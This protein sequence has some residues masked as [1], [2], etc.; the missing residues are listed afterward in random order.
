[1]RGYLARI[2]LFR[3]LPVAVLQQV[4]EVSEVRRFRKGEMLFEENRPARTVWL[5]QRGWVHVVKRT[6]QGTLATL[7]TVTPEEVL[8]G[9]SAVVGCAAYYASAI[10]ATETAAVS[11]PQETFARLIK[12]Q[13]GFAEDFL[14]L[15]HTRMQHL[16]QTVSLAQAPVEQRL[17]HILLRLRAAFGRTLPVTHHE[18]SRMAG[19]RWETSI[20]T[21]SSMKQRGWI[22]SS[23]GQ[24]TILVPQ[25]L[26]MLLSNGRASE[27][28]PPGKCHEHDAHHS[29]TK[30]VSARVSLTGR[31]RR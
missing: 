8:C 4:G 25:Q 21:L 23:R 29:L 22:A 14:R 12:R 16:A 17:A 15:Y 7:F 27:T 5:I 6:P 2:P 24:V 10:T 9:F 18:L 19:T 11:V 20:R 30:A 31:A 3:S 13:P 28:S 1:M 26:R